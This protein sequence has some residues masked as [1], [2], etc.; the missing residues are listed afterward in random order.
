MIS[1][2]KGKII[3]K[4]DKFVVLNANN[5]GYKVFLSRKNMPNIS[6]GSDM[7]LFCSLD[8][9][10]NSMNLYGF[11]DQSELDFFEILESIRGIGPKAALEISSLGP[12]EKIKEK[13][14]LGEENIFD[15]IPGIGRKK[16]MSIIVELS[17]KIKELP[18]KSDDTEEALVQLGFPRQKV[19]EALKS[20]SDDVKNPE[21]R[22]KQ[23]LK[24][25]GK[26]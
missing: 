4:K 20:V 13:I 12:L 5:V 2:L 22:M 16:A 14:Q 24:F 6:L 1:Y 8:V 26:A 7:E 11:L 17:G 3:L 21:E 25:L 18:R 19:R 15:S 10:E 23:A 9:K